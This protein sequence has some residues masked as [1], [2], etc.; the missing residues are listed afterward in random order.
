MNAKTDDR[1]DAV[2]GQVDRPVRPIVERLRAVAE[3][4]GQDYCAEAADVIERMTAWLEG[5]CDCP[6]CGELRACADGCT[7]ATDCP[8]EADRMAG[9]RQALYGA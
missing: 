4:C 8:H 7:F 9:A 2:C 5:D 6:C 3:N 1:S